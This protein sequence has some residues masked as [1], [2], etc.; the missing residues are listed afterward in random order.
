M[1]HDLPDTSLPP[2][3][4]VSAPLGDFL[5]A[6]QFL[7]VIPIR[8]NYEPS[9]P[10]EGLTRAVAWFPLVAALIGC[11]L[12]LV[13]WLMAPWFSIEIRDAAIL[14]S[15][16]LLT[17]MLHLDGFVDCCDGLLGTRSMERR[18]EIM[19][20]SRVGAYGTLGAVLLLLAQFTALNALPIP[21]R[22]L[23][24][25]VAPTL[26]RWI[27]VA[28]IVI[29]PYARAQGAGTYYRRESINFIQA[30][31]VTIVTLLVLS[32][33]STQIPQIQVM[34]LSLHIALTSLSIMTIWIWIA[35]LAAV[36]S[37]IALGWTRWASSKL[38]GGLTGDTYGAINEIVMLT[39][40][41]ALPIVAR[42][43]A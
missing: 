23:G 27:M 40:W 11:C 16:A 38:N 22:A 28:A 32:P 1:P 19:R 15:S 8:F 3:P 20:D 29:Y 35:V 34:P 24:L 21:L 6:V 41:I 2:G 4:R 14:G 9:D 10:D 12:M 43:I 30:T 36:A 42:Y 33:L 25:I 37:G 31:L 13:D 5:L 7:T 18:L 39:V 26:G 17:G